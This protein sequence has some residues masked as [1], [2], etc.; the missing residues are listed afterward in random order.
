LAKS[1]LKTVFLER[2]NQ[3]IQ[4]ETGGHSCGKACFC[5]A[6]AAAT[7]VGNCRKVLLCP[8]TILT[9]SI[10]SKLLTNK[11]TLTTVWLPEKKEKEGEGVEEEEEE[12]RAR[13]KHFCTIFLAAFSS[14]SSTFVR[15]GLSERIKDES[16]NTG[17]PDF[18][19]RLAGSLAARG[20]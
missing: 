7:K 16:L 20:A 17:A 5:I 6:A 9:S 13:K 15:F 14:S 3:N 19:T 11:F 1:D 10:F 8:L 12:M 2:E 4:L 18:D